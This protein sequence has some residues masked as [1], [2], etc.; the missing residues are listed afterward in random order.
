MKQLARLLVVAGVTGLLMLV[1]FGSGASCDTGDRDRRSDD[2]ESRLVGKPAPDLKGD[3]AI[4]GP[5]VSLADL[6]GKVV[7]L[8]FWAVW[9]GPCIATFP[10]LSDWHKDFHEDGLEIVG[11]TTYFEKYRFNRKEGRLVNALKK[12]EVNG[13]TKL[14]G[15]LTPAEEHDMLTSFVRYY[16]LNYRILVLPHK[17]WTEAMKNY[18]F[19]GIPTLV[20]IDRMGVVRLVQVGRPDE[21]GV[22][23]IQAEI[24]KLLAQR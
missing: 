1:A 6:K 14:V 13:K 3:F 16:R 15:R 7:L 2:E 9:C 22:D 19:D 23:A 18:G 17:A 8:D 10:H 5:A 4:N 21:A 11:V 24:R 12:E 20:L